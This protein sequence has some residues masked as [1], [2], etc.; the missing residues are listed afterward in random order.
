MSLLKK[1]GLHRNDVRDIAQ[2]FHLAHTSK[3]R[4][5][6]RRGVRTS[7]VPPHVFYY[8]VCTFFDEIKAKCFALAFDGREIFDCQGSSLKWNPNA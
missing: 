1:L 2:T 3:C 4:E 5:S 6:N 7:N 8:C